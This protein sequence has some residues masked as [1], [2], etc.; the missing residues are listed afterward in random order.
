MPI[1]VS[2]D[3]IRPTERQAYWTEAICR[4]FANIETKPLGSTVVS[5]HFEFVEIGDAKLV[6]FDSSPQC[7]TRNAKLVS[8]AGSDEF[9]FDFQ[10]RGHSAM[11]Q[12][13]NEG[14]INPGYG[15]LYD[16]RRPFED[17]LFGPEHR[18]EVLIATVPAASLLRAL[19]DAERL[20]ARPVPLAGAVA[21]SIAAVVRTAIA[22]PSGPTN[23]VGPDIVA[24]LSA[25]LRIAAGA[26][27]QLSRPD[28]FYLIDGYLR[29][30][31][32]T[33]RSAPALAAEFGISERTFHRIF[34]DRA[35]TFE[36]HVLHLRVELFR[37]LLRQPSLANI[38]IARLAHQCGFADA[39]H[40]TRT[41]KDRFGATPRDFR[42]NQQISQASQ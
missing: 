13:G 26:S 34:A 14:T 22:V 23:R 5:G 16:A 12:A 6:R 24:Y 41:F 31:I 8:R 17:R 33:A 9:M 36:R 38:S 20:C 35:T 4:S 11:V 30:Y 19:P 21:R 32:A 18:A 10:R 27:H 25:L 15:V 28:L 3:P 29:T 1:S 2:T 42:A 7:Y 39:A 37:D 40:A